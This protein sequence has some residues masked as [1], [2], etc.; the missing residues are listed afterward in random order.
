MSKTRCCC[1]SSVPRKCYEERKLRGNQPTRAHLENGHRLMC[2]GDIIQVSQRY[3]SE[4]TIVPCVGAQ[5]I[6]G[7]TF[8]EDSCG[9]AGVNWM[10]KSTS[11]TGL[12][13]DNTFRTVFGESFGRMLCWLLE[14]ISCV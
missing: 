5:N 3:C 13:Y 7:C 10:R 8:E 14:L 9:F 4:S 11:T 2:V 12:Q 1:V 6:D